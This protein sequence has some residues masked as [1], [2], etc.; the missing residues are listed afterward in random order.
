MMIRG[1][2][3]IC[4]FRIHHRNL[5]DALG[6]VRISDFG[7]KHNGWFFTVFY[8]LFR[9][10]GFRPLLYIFYVSVLS[11]VY[12]YFQEPEMKR[13]IIP[14]LSDCVQLSVEQ[15]RNKL[16]DIIRQ[17]KF[18]R[19]KVAAIFWCREENFVIQRSSFGGAWHFM[20]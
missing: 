17:E 5:V 13:E 15:Y 9:N 12:I 7:I 19:Y 6:F 1:S 10:L 18:F 4:G 2:Y 8:K 3:S 16:Y 14:P 20:V 11:I